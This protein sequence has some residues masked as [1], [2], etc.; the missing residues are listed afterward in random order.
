MRLTIRHTTRYAFEKPASFGLQQLRKTPKST[1]QQTVRHWS[2]EIEGGRKELQFE[3]HHNN[4]VELLLGRD[5]R[6]DLAL[7]A[8]LPRVQRIEFVDR[9]DEAAVVAHAPT[10][11]RRDRSV[12][13]GCSRRNGRSRARRWRR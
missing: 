12:S 13:R 6:C 3:D 7:H 4:M 2:T 10:L 11:P 9:A 8:V 1:H 5:R